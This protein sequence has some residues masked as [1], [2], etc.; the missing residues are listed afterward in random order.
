MASS[1]Q[2]Q[3]QLA[4][5][6]HL[7]HQARREQKNTKQDRTKIIAIVLIIAMVLLTTGG[8]ILGRIFS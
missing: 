5:E 3:R 2:R 7:S 8:F 6:K 1:N 4:R